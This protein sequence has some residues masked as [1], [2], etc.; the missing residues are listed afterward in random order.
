M[1]GVNMTKLEG[2]TAIRELADHLIRVRV[3]I[4]GTLSACE[5]ELYRISVALRRGVR[6]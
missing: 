3:Q 2:V 6:K 1:M 4:N 5:Q